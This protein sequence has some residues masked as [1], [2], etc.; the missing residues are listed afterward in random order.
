MVDKKSKTKPN[1][2][3][4]AIT[5]P[6]SEKKKI[7]T[8]NKTEKSQASNKTVDTPKSNKTDTVKSLDKSRSTQR[9]D[10][11][12]TVNK[13]R[14]IPRTNLSNK[15]TRIEKPSEIDIHRDNLSVSVLSGQAESL[16]IA[17]PYILCIPFK[18]NIKKTPDTSIIRKKTIKE[19][20]NPR[21]RAKEKI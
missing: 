18:N 1:V 21:K 14:S 10:T 17:S 20:F 13:S 3:K 2:V 9:T 5:P 15:S 6:I 19:P 11:E 12:N 8:V 7:D 4:E 16:S